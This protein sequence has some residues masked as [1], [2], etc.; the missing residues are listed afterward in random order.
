VKLG[1]SSESEVTFDGRTLTL[2]RMEPISWVPWVAGEVE[3]NAVFL[4]RITCD[5][6]KDDMVEYFEPWCRQ[7]GNDNAVDRATAHR[8]GR[9]ALILFKNRVG[10]YTHGR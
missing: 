10:T 8:N 4:S 7:L 6:S 1:T 5:F 3:N 2:T 9:A